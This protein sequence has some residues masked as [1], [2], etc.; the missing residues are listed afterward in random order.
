MVERFGRKLAGRIDIV[1][2]ATP[3]DFYRQVDAAVAP[4]AG[5]SPRM[6]A[7]ALAAGVPALAL[8]HDGLG[9]VYAPMLQD[10]GFGEDLTATSLDDYV[11]KAEALA[12]S[13]ET[14]SRVAAAISAVMASPESSAAMIARAIED[15][16][17]R[18]LMEHAA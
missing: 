17:R 14:R 6:V 2:A 16:A 10:L 11:A 7:E 3:E 9:Q 5:V 15:A 12:S 8:Q 18:T 1:E 4:R 13:S